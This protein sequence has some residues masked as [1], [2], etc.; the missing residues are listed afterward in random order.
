[1]L[2]LD[3]RALKLAIASILGKIKKVCGAS[4]TPEYTLRRDRPARFLGLLSPVE[5]RGKPAVN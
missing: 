4:T 5:L 1:M 3:L 2:L